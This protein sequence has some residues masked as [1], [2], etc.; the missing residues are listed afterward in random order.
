MA[1]KRE[2]RRDHRHRQDQ[3]QGGAGRRRADARELAHRTVPNAVRDRRPLPAFRR[4]AAL[5][6]HLRRARRLEPRGAD[7]RDLHRRARLGR[8]LHLAAQTTATGWRCRSST[9]SSPARTSS[10]PTMTRCARPSPRRCRRG[11][12]AGSISARRSSGSSGVSRTARRGGAPTSPIRNTGPGGFSG[13]AATE[14]CS[15]GCHTDLWNPRA[16]SLV[17]PGRDDGLATTCSRRCARLSTGS[18]RCVPDLA[19]RLGLGGRHRVL[20]GIHDSSAS[21]L[22]HL[23]AREP[24]FTV[25]STGTWMIVFAIGGDIDRLDPTRDTLA[26]V[27]PSAIRCLPRAS[28]AGANSSCSPAAT[29]AEPSAA[30]IDRVIARQVMALPTFV[31]GVGPFPTARAAGRANPATLSPGERNAAASLYLALMTAESMACAGAAGPDDRRGTVRRKPR[32]TAQRL[33]RSRA[34]TCSRRQE[35]AARA[36]APPA[37]RT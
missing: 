12:P 21:L 17:E 35:P 24:P 11:C 32:S 1:A 10:P 30:D 3:R 29:R 7:R 9:T 33:R 23:I 14:M 13:V 34:A 8:R 16:R 26:N 36:A 19:Q 15:L 28:W 22:P 37:S 25:V 4:R 18:G 27:T 2:A 5:G 20:C 31:P 6:F